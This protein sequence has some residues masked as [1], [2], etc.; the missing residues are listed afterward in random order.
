MIFAFYGYNE[1]QAGEAGLPAFK[2]NVAA[3]IKHTLAQQYNGRSAPRLA[4]FSPI[5]HEFID[6]SNLPSR[7]A[8]AESNRRLKLYCDAMA[9]VCKSQGILFVDVFSALASSPAG[10]SLTINGI[11]PTEQGDRLIAAAGVRGLFPDKAQAAM[12]ETALQSLRAAVNDKNWHWFYR[13]RTTD[14]YSTYGDRA[15]LKFVGGQTNYEVAQRELEVL[16]VQT[17]NR[18]KVVWAA[19]QG[20]NIKPDDS[21]LPPFIPVVT[22]KPGT[23]PG[24]KHLFQGGEEAIRLMTVHKDMKVELFAD[25]TKFPELIGP[26]QMA[27]DT[28]GRLWVA[29]WP[30]YPH[31]KPT[32]PMNDK[33]LILEDTDGDG[34]ADRST[35]FVDDIQNPTGFEFWNG[36]VLVAQGPDLLFLKDTDGDD[37]YDVKQRIVHGL[38]TADTHHTANSFVLDPGGSLYFQEGTFHHSQVESPWGPAR[39]VV[40]GAVFRY[41][42][43]QQRADVYVTFGFANPHGHVFDAWAQ[44]IV[45]DGTGAVPYHGIL[46]SSLLNFPQKH[47][48][49]PTVYQ[50]RTRPCPGLEILSSSHFPEEY[51]GRL[52]VPNVIGFQG[53][54]Q[55]KLEDRDSSLG[56]TELQPIVSSTDP[57][58]RPA[59]VEVGPDGAIYFL[60]WQNPIIG[61]MQH[62]LRDPSRDHQHGRVYRVTYNG[63]TLVKPAPI[64]GL[65]IAQLLER[66]QDPDDRVRYRVRIELSGRPSKEVI[67]ATQT[68]AAALSTSDKDYEHHLLEA[69][70]VHQ[71]HNTVNRPLLE[72]VLAST[73]WRARAA[74]VRVLQAWHEQVPNTLEL[75]RRAAAD[76]SSPVRLMAIWAASFV[77]Q[78]EA[79]EV[80]LIAGDY[81]TDLY[82]EHLTKEVLKT[83]QPLVN[84][85]QKE[86]RPLAF[87]SAAGARYVLKGLST[88]ELLKQERTQGVLVEL[89][90]RSGISDA[91]RREAVVSLARTEKK[92]EV[93]VVMDAI[94]TLDARGSGADVGLVFDL[95]RQLTGRSTSELESVRAEIEKLAL[96]ARQPILRQIGYVSLINI[97]GQVE[98]AWKLAAESPPRLVDFCNALPL[99]ADAS[100][101]ATLYEK[102]EPLVHGLPPGAAK[103]QGTSGRFVRVELPG[104]GTLTLAEVEVYS[105]GQNV[106]RNGRANQKNTGA[107]GDA[108][109]GID[110]KKSGSF[111]DGGQTHT[112]E[113]TGKPYWEVDLGDE[114]PIER[115]DIY[116]RTDGSLGNRLNNFTLLVLN[117]QRQ[118]VYRKDQNPA[119]K[120]S[121]EIA[122]PAGSS[123]V[124]VRRAAMNA[125]TSVRGQELKTFQTLA[126]FVRSGDERTTAI[127]ALQ[128]LPHATWPKDEAPALAKVLVESLRHTPAKD[129]TSDASLDAFDFADALSTLLPADQA[130][131]L[132]ADLGEL[133]VRVIKI[134]TVFEK[135][136][137][138][139]ELI[140]VQAG[141][142]VEFV[143]ENSDLMPHN[144][145]IVRP[146]ALEEVGMQAE[147]SAQQPG[148]AERQFVPNSPHVLAKSQLLQPRATQKVS[149]M[150]PKTPGVYPFV[151]TYP[152][153]WRRMYGAL[154]VVADLDAYLANPDAYLVAAKIEPQDALLKDRRPRTEWTFA[155]L[156]GAAETLDHAA[157]G[158]T[159]GDDHASRSFGNGKQ[160]FTVANCVA[161][162][163][164]GDVGHQFGPELA[165]LDPKLKPSDILRHVLEPSE[166]IEEKYQTQVI[167]L[168]NGRVVQGMVVEETPEVVKLIENPLVKADPVVVPKSQIEE[169]TV[170]KVSIM[171]KGL[172][173]KLTRDEI[174][175][176]VSFL[177]A[178]GDSKHVIFQSGHH[179]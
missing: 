142:P 54:L 81:P 35:T 109:R 71:H 103:P 179:H 4:L 82:I 104:K 134:G 66:L 92:S 20:R 32:T 63:R 33:L 60:D 56:A 10:Q 161:C 125:L 61:H 129:R 99:V 36:G 123:E 136:S 176:L 65:P 70:W 62:N 120:P 58:F 49:P 48:R 7:E 6:D 25:E 98:P 11:H 19:A 131:K 150:V 8:V 26:V 74:A 137:Y 166:K 88:D 105:G 15:F 27:F 145:V 37:R 149:F 77:R 78:A 159:H 146:G 69:L 143:L 163:K 94:H 170:S 76:E 156:A 169:R 17:S 44:D 95:V 130:K 18:D 57:N 67:A 40:N 172:L 168:D 119:P 167:Q 85:A 144:F 51:R 114:Y 177:A 152:G 174:L 127:R 93:R 64:S 43:R 148:F 175:D 107:G 128:H 38:D 47:G 90:N 102:I 30:N 117:A 5:A 151:C 138:D 16:D 80:L 91:V 41:E 89:I 21:N 112:E 122:L 113:N 165:K 111:G 133:G 97:D 34:R 155:S 100:V 59:D 132:R 110:G 72:R 86:K 50:Q 46:F 87:A 9:E 171:P 121:V 53:I 164:I 2:E 23:L 22:N 14:G 118:E 173:D 162:H 1:S 13:H 106:A 124:L 160:L 141:K 126:G 139:K 75:L 52:L 135:M 101:R 154:Y 31:W 45:V 3:F 147:A 96:T 73:N 140:A 116:N 55:Y 83:L 12:D 42:P 178:R 84:E 68:W 39:R 28:R 108:S 115:I 24:G 29:V 79:I 157:M 153:H 158:H